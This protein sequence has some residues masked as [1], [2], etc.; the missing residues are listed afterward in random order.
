[1]IKVAFGSV[2]KDGGT[3]TFYRNLRPVLK[4]HGV[5]L[6]CVT[7]GKRER[8]LVEKA[9]VDD[10]C[11]LLASEIGSIKKQAQVFSDWCDRENI[12]VVMAINSV[13]ILSAL[14]HL[15]KQVRVLSRCANGFEEGYRITLSGQDR[16]MRIIALTPRLKRDLVENYGVEEQI[17]HLV[18]N[19][20]NPATFA[21][22]AMRVRAMPENKPVQLGF[23]G[24]LEHKQKGVLYL[25]KIVE[26]LARLGVDFRLR[27]AGKGVHRAVLEKA[28]AS[29]I[30]AGKVE[31]LGAIAKDEVPTFLEATDV[32]LFTSHFEGCPNALLEAMMAGCVPVALLI[33]GIT[34]FIIDSGRTGFVAPMS[35][36]AAVARYVADLINDREQLRCV[37][38]AAAAEARGRFTSEVAARRYAHQLRSVMQSSLPAFDPLPWS[39]FAVDP[40]YQ[41]RLTGYIPKMVKA[42][43]KSAM[44]SPMLAGYFQRP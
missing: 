8:A 12:D 9:Y 28:L 18:P 20:I 5:D 34:D 33:D 25:P 22:A 35:D 16:L 40:V 7:V 3:F 36:C 30:K 29:Y 2:P 24:R 31:F 4:Q 1:M 15:S 17:I 39:Q 42:P 44:K 21:S 27:I 11:V 38:A 43:I 10:G 41:K 26:A 23:V 37:S 32:F 19:G 13:A 6:R 14:P